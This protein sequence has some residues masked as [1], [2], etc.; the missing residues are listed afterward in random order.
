MMI[1]AVEKDAI[2]S[3][4]LYATG[5]AAL[6]TCQPTR[7]DENGRYSLIDTCRRRSI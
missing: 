4:S 5:L 2:L 6:K 1:F 3:E 7:S